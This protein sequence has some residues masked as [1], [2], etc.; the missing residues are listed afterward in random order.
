[1]NVSLM[2]THLKNDNVNEAL[3]IFFKLVKDDVKLNLPNLLSL[4]NHLL[5]KQRPEDALLT[6]EHIDRTR[7]NS[8]DRRAVIR[9]LNAAASQGDV[10][11]TRQLFEK[12]KHKVTIDRTVLSALIK[13]H[14][15]R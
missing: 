4:T 3:D 9:V 8:N 13:V 12:L 15:V 6:L 14:L 5:R 1:M 10:E 2:M 7:V 11:L